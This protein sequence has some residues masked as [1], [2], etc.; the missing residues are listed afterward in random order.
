MI[1]SRPARLMAAAAR[2]VCGAAVL[3]AAAC[4]LASCSASSPPR[5]HAPFPG[6]A[7]SGAFTPAPLEA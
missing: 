7:S 2:E 3:T 4:A 6:P 5:G 1:A